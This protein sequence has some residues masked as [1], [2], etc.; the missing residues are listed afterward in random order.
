MARPPGPPG[1]PQKKEK[2]KQD[3]TDRLDR[4]EGHTLGARDYIRYGHRGNEEKIMCKICGV[5]IASLIP[6][7]S[8][9]EVQQRGNQ[10][11]IRERLVMAQTPQYVAL[12]MEMDDGSAH[13]TPACLNC[14]NTANLDQLEDAYMADLEVML[15]LED[16]RRGGEA[17][18]EKLDRKP[19]SRGSIR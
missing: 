5:V 11:V 6:D 12:T 10:T 15:D 8:F 18:W 3:I 16:N 1:R 9:K 4:P 7:D 2:I 17:P 14:A 19:V 13:E